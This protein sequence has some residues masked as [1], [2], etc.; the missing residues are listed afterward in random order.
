M[1][2]TVLLHTIGSGLGCQK[3]VGIC[4]IGS[5]LWYK[6]E[7]YIQL[8]R[9]LLQQPIG[10]AAREYER[11]REREMWFELLFCCGEYLDE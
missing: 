10:Q 3:V 2:G 9:W 5:A 7:P 1:N 11:E 8:V 4:N 6:P